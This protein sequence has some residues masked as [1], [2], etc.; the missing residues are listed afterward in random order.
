MPIGGKSCNTIISEAQPPEKIYEAIALELL[1]RVIER[2]EDGS[3]H[4]IN[5]DKS[6]LLVQIE[7]EKMQT[8]IPKLKSE[9]INYGDTELLLLEMKKHSNYIWSLNFIKHQGLQLKLIGP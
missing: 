6:L 2:S 8:V 9:W 7:M 5:G 1:T 3:I 4:R